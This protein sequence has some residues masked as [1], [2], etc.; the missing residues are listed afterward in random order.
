MKETCP[1]KEKKLQKKAGR[2]AAFEADAALDEAV[3]AF[4]RSGYEGT[5][6]AQIASALGATKPSLYRLFG[7]KKTLFL[8]ALKHYAEKSRRQY[9]EVLEAPIHLREALERLLM[10]AN[11]NASKP[12][13]PQG[14]FLACVAVAETHS[15]P[16]AGEIFTQATRQFEEDIARRMARALDEA[17]LPHSFPVTRRAR[18]FVSLIL[19]NALR[20]RSGAQPEELIDTVDDVLTCVLGQTKEP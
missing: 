18:L 9:L 16:E 4:W 20:A 1:F 12:H 14:C 17:D 8:E 7:C 2:P 13:E 11:E 6:L 3:C 15:H 10:Q 5:D 19:A